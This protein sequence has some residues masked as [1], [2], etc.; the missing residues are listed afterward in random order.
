MKRPSCA[1]KAGA[2]SSQDQRRAYEANVWKSYVYAGLMDCSL[3][4]PIWVLYLRDERGFSLTQITLLEVPLFVLIVLAEVPAGAVADRFGRKCSLMLGS[5]IL[6]LAM[7]VFG[8]GTDYAVILISNLAW[9]LAF[10]FRSGADTALLYDSLK[11]AGRESAFQRVASR[12]WA[13]RSAAGL[14]GLLLGAPIAAATSY[15]VAIMLS[16]AV[17]GCAFLAAALLHEPKHLPE[18]AQEGY[19]RTL[20][21]GVREAWRAPP[22]RYLFLYSGIL[23]AGAAGPLQLL[24]QP[25]LVEHGIGTAKLGL[26]QA[27]VQATGVLSALAAGWLLSRLGERGTFGALPAALSLC[28]LALVGTDRSWIAVAFLGIAAVRG[29]HEPVLAGYIN[30]R[31]ASV[32]RATVLSVQ[33]AVTNTVMAMVWPLAG[34]VADTSGTRATFS[35]YAAGSLLLG[36]GTLLLW[37]RADRNAATSAATDEVEGRAG[38]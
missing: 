26:W 2:P 10:T 24:Q 4:A 22:L 29:L 6:S 15:G 23:A 25:W 3:T 18:H 11:H 20:V 19:L 12:F 32:R 35:M 30:R 36:G 38:D 31:V 28:G 9:G 21:S 1:G 34:I 5:G 33:S 7:F 27:S 13:V 14:A 37:S 16:A 8:V 17:H